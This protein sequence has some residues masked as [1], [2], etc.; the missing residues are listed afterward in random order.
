MMQAG[1]VS[2]QDADPVSLLADIA[3]R[4]R[5]PLS[6]GGEVRFACP[7]CG[8]ESKPGQ[9]HFHVTERGAHCFVCGRSMGLSRFW[10]WRYG[11]SGADARSVRVHVRARAAKPPP[12][13][14]QW[15]TMAEEYV[16][17]VCQ[18]PY[19]YALWQSYKPLSRYTIKR[20]EFGVGV[21]LD[22]SCRHERLIYPARENGKIAGIYGRRLTCHC[23]QKILMSRGSRKTL[24]G[25]DDLIP[26]IPTVVVENPVD[27][28]LIEQ[29][30][31]TWDWCVQAVAV[32]SAGIWRDEWSL[33]LLRFK[34]AHVMIWLDN[35]LAGCARGEMRERLLEE[36]RRDHPKAKLP[37]V[38]H[39]P[40][41]ARRIFSVGVETSLFPWPAEAPPKCDPGDFVRLYRKELPYLG[42]V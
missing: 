23:P 17:R 12:P 1:R 10:A 42:V 24:Y 30:C 6:R 4:E 21:L 34:V 13:P 8:K 41:T 11:G 22:S 20:R 29:Q 19:R 2:A 18:H 25:I 37:P 26:C 32:G 39:G 36:W 16:A 27:A 40:R 3:H 28:A 33:K 31:N 15:P 9:V 38:M 35:D 7:W 14:P 5:Q